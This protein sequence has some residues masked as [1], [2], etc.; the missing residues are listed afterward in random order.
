MQITS[1]WPLP[2]AGIRFL[3]PQ[4]LLQ[5]LSQN[6]LSNS[7]YPVA[8]G[9]YP[10]ATDH[11]MVRN[12]H[13]NNLFIYC[14]AGR[15]TLTV[16]GKLHRV[17]AGDLI[18]LPKGVAHSYTAHRKHP[19]TIYW[20][21]F[22]GH[23]SK[24]FCQHLA[25]P[26]V[27]QQIGLQPKLIADLDFLFSVRT[28]AYNL[29]SFIHGCHELQQ[30]MSYMALLVRQQ[31]SKIGTEI[32]LDD[33]RSFMQQH[34]HDQINL[35]TLAKHSQL[36]KYHFS[37]RFKAMTGHSPIQYFINMKMQHACYLLDS[38]AQSIKKIA[39]ILGYDDAYYFSRL[40]KKV[41]GLS[42]DQYRKNKHR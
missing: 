26:S 7:L 23:L 30:I 40:F 42:P 14:I 27:I 4:S 24:D 29:D 5:E 15:G 37:K 35:D 20:L 2:T 16:D 38:S 39:D 13:S 18:V 19:W 36:S 21:H 34:I 17:R 8:M 6:S 33:T 12:K 32:N 3:T 25:M 1:N 41:I 9:F 31:R 11:L 28:S 22:D 10:K